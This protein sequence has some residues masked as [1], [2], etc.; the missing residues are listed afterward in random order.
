MTT[1]DMIT[2]DDAEPE[3]ESKTGGPF[4]LPGQPHSQTGPG[5][6]IEHWWQTVSQADYDAFAP[7]LAEYGAHDLLEIGRGLAQLMHWDNCPDRTMYEL[8]CWFYLKGKIERAFEALAAH[9]L[10]SDDTAH[11]ATTYTMMIRRIRNQGE[12]R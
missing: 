4:D 8:G 7:K 12:L 11:D 3:P 5:D 6:G 9:H 1:A 2:A 10:P